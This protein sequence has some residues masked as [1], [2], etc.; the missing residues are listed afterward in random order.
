M[1]GLRNLLLPFSYLLSYGRQGYRIFFSSSSYPLSYGWLGTESSFPLPPTP[2]LMGDR[3]RNLLFLF[4]LPPFLWVTGYGIFFSSSSY[5]LSYGWQ[6]TESSFPL[7][8]TLCLDCFN[9]LTTGGPSKLFEAWWCHLRRLISYIY[10]FC[11]GR[12]R[13]CFMKHFS[14][15]LESSWERRSHVARDITMPRTVWMVRLWYDIYSGNTDTHV[16]KKNTTLQYAAI[17]QAPIFVSLLYFLNQELT[18]VYV[19]IVYA[20]TLMSYYRHVFPTLISLSS[21]F[22]KELSAIRILRWEFLENALYCFSHMFLC[23]YFFLSFQFLVAEHGSVQKEKLTEDYNDAYPLI[24]LSFLW[25]DNS[26]PFYGKKLSPERESP[27]Q[28]GQL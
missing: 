9:S 19:N 21:G 27:S 15:S 4:L 16:P 8:P 10:F 13:L 23:N 5:P 3:V 18:F 28:L 24:F 14:R 7:P 6:G 17:F 2:C 22:T 20:V 1:K 12:S 11:N 25:I 26:L